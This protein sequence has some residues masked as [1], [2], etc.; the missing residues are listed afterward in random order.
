MT[1]FDREINLN[2][3][4]DILA[5]D[6]GVRIEIKS[7][8]SL[9][10][11]MPFEFEVTDGFN[12]ELLYDPDKTSAILSV[13]PD[14]ITQ[15]AVQDLK[16]NGA[17]SKLA[18][19]H[20]ELVTYLQHIVSFQSG[21]GY[22]FSSNT[23][24][25]TT[26]FSLSQDDVKMLNVFASSL[27]GEREE[28][29]FVKDRAQ[30]LGYFM[31]LIENGKDV[32]VFTHGEPLKA[33]N[34]CKLFYGSKLMEEIS[35]IIRENKGNE[36]LKNLAIYSILDRFPSSLSEEGFLVNF[37]KNELG[38]LDCFNNQFQRINTNPNV[39]LAVNR[40]DDLDYP[41]ANFDQQVDFLYRITLRVSI[42]E[43]FRAELFSLNTREEVQEK[44]S[45][46]L[47]QMRELISSEGY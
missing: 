18:T 29:L 40:N 38:D 22:V 12:K 15:E 26:F 24:G 20:H 34:T 10:Y 16:N 6:F 17:S 23:T 35:P 36:R 5:T 27:K 28:I 32:E 41:C 9:P 3:L 31:W 47:T 7:D 19:V 37:I 13:H 30:P 21:N 43:D 46:L 39:I 45:P 4:N 8:D 25:I 42:P 14:F 44:L 2:S 33:Y 1:E 11:L